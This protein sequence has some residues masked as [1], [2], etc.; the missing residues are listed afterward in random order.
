MAAT[1]TLARRLL[2]TLFPWFLLL[3][4]GLTALQITV[5]SISVNRAI[6][7]DLDSLARTVAPSV[8]EAVWELDQ[9][10]LDGLVQ[11]LRLNAIVTGVRVTTDSGEQ[12]EIQGEVPGLTG[13][14]GLAKAARVPLRYR[15]LRGAWME[16][17]RLEIYSDASVAWARLRAGL[18]VTVGTSLA[19]AAGLWLIFSAT[20]RG[21]LAGTVSEAAST[22]AGWGEHPADTPAARIQ[23]PYHD[24]LGELFEAL[25][26]HR[27][28]LA[29]SMQ[30]LNSVNQNLEKIVAARTFE[31]REAKEAAESADHLKSAF[32]ATMSHELRTPL[33][34]IIGF[35]GVLLQELAGP[36]NGEQKKQMGL[37]RDS[38]RHLLELINDV[39]DLSKIEAGQLDVAREPVELGALA[40]KVT[41]SLQ[42]LADRKGLQLACEAAETLNITS[43]RRRVEQILVNLVGNAIKFTEAGAVRLRVAAQAGQARVEVEDTGIGIAPEDQERLFRP[44]SQIDS[45]LSRKYGGTGLGLSICRKLCGLLGGAIEVASAPGRGSRFVVTLPMGEP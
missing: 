12:L 32:L 7:R 39:L 30:D 1:R 34:S 18:Y 8:T 36:L 28:R 16:I 38:S 44:F 33:N 35:T 26:S 17:G 6:R 24:E 15:S 31:L 5:H 20:I 37:V 2:G 22:V 13:W 14:P 9:P 40:H 41:Q 45:G 4:A 23:Y 3:A 25:N 27:E 21:H 43:D 11:G 42:P 19:L 10:N 29:A